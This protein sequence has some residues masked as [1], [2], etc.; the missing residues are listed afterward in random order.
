MAQSWGTNNDGDGEADP[1]A[2]DEAW[3]QAA[4]VSEADIRRPRPAPVPAPQPWRTW[5]PPAPAPV[6]SARRRGPRLT[7]TLTVLLGLIVLVVVFAIRNTSRSASRDPFQSQQRPAPT[8]TNAAP[9]VPPVPVTH[10]PD[11]TGQ[12]PSKAAPRQTAAAPQRALPWTT[13]NAMPAAGSDIGRGDVFATIKVGTCLATPSD[14][15]HI[16]TVPC[17]GPHT[18]EVTVLRDLTPV[19]GTMP[20]MDQIQD[21]QARTCPD[22]AQRW[23]G[24]GGPQYA[25]GYVWVFENGTPGEAVRSFACTA[26]LAGHSPFSGTLRNAGAR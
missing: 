23:L 3:V 5:A 26:M 15:Y 17:S 1:P 19:F 21:F 2:F 9:A 4:K 8:T 20:T 12:P 11:P 25:S 16:T 18:D 22:A 24:G 14:L 6:L 13:A 10:T 7:G